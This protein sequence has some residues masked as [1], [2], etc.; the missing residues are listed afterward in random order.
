MY[1][2]FGVF[3]KRLINSLFPL[4]VVHILIGI[5]N[6]SE[7]SDTSKKREDSNSKDSFYF[8][9]IYPF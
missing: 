1:N 5:D 9:Y 2:L 7:K 8:L 4:S 3:L 6:L